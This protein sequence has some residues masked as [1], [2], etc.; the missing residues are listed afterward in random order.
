MN[1]YVHFGR[2]DILIITSLSVHEHGITLHL[3]KSLISA[4]FCSFQ[5]VDLLHVLLNISMS[6]DKVLRVKTSAKHESS[7]LRSFKIYIYIYI[8]KYFIFY[9]VVDV[10]IFQLL[11]AGIIEV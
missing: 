3:F 1:L 5:D 8:H 4:G 7:W 11:I 6:S 10:S 2:N 9:T